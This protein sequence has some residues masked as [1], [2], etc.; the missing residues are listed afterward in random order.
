[1]RPLTKQIIV[2]LM[3]FSLASIPLHSI[4]AETIQESG[5]E[6]SL[7]GS[8]LLQIYKQSAASQNG[9]ALTITDPNSGEEQSLN[10]NDL[11]PG[12]SS[13]ADNSGYFPD[14]N[15]PST[16]TLADAYDDESGMG[17]AGSNARNS[18]WSDANSGDPTVSGAAY[19]V[20][21]DASNRSRPDFS[22]DPMMSQSKQTFNDMDL[23]AEGFGDCSVETEINKNTRP[24]HLPD[25]KRCNRIVDRSQVCEVTHTYEASIIDY[26][27]G[28]Y[29]LASCGDGCLEMW[30]GRVGNN[31]LTGNCTIH[32]QQTAVT[33]R[34]PEA[35]ISATLEYA[36]WDDYMQVYVG[37]PGQETKVWQSSTQ[38]PPETA[39]RCERDSSPDADLNTDVTQYFRNAAEGDVLNFKIRLSV[40]DLGEGYGRI[41]IRYDP[42]KAVTKDVWAPEECINSAKGVSDGFAQGQFTCLSDPSGGGDCTIVDDMR[43]CKSQLS[44]SPFPGISNLCEK[45]QVE[46]DY[47][48]F[49]TGT[50][51]CFT[52][53][54]GNQQCPEAGT[55]E[56]NSC[57]EFEENPSCGFI[58]STCVGG[59]QGESGECYVHED[60]YDCGSNVTIPTYDKTDTYSCGGEIKCMGDECLDISQTQSQ[61]FAKAAAL[62]NAAEF[63]TQDM[64]CTGVDENGV[65]TGDENVNCEAFAGKKGECKIAV[66]GISDCCN[67]PVNVSMADYLN[68]LNASKKLGAAIFKLDSPYINAA[69]G[70]YQTLG[71]SAAQS[72][73]EVTQPFATYVENIAGAVTDFVQPVTDFARELVNMLKEQLQKVLNEILTRLGYEGGS[74]A[75]QGAASNAMASIMDSGAAQL[76]GEVMTAYGYVALAIA[77]IQ[78]VYQCE[79][80]EFEVN[81][82]RELKSCHFIGS[83]CKTEA[84][85]CIEKREVYCCYNSPLSRIVQEQARPQLG[86]G[87]GT[88][89]E[90][91]CGGIPLDRIA[92]IDWNAVN[93]DE[94]TGILEENGMLAN[95]DLMNIESLTG[96][97]SGLNLESNPRINATDRTL[98]RL[99]G[100]DVDS[101]RSDTAS[102]L[103]GQLDKGQN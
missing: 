61:D 28:P 84:I 52:D 43:V 67:T 13:T 3:N 92:E 102:D 44:P 93:L 103:S 31:Y 101:I 76:I 99:D 4:A 21:L 26:H 72:W 62:L 22:S 17:D 38:F 51:E 88:T 96:E 11:F 98:Q 86:I 9:N 70:A 6:A 34:N 68:L 57:S 100:I 63:M 10:I 78:M 89:D 48:G 82:K 29:N 83:Y 80:E 64:S 23:I 65:A 77:V 95:Q 85:G 58:S 36:K 33:V 47:S 41:K 15:T 56:L 81:A 37:N 90:P 1:M 30:I 16:S 94:W 14:N 75:A 5:R 55:A 69:K 2:Y 12:T 27:S 71:E 66:G 60:T 87:W 91:L 50:N 39:G 20:L 35:I 40:T 18:L 53:I 73:S 8:E 32:E 59:A 46:T 45:V 42:A 19:K 54:N 7:F 79:E 24:V 25:Y 97:G 49:Y 74:A